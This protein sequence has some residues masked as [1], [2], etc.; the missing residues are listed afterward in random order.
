MERMGE[1]LWRKLMDNTTGRT[2]GDSDV[3]VSFVLIGVECL[4][5][6]ML[7]VRF[8]VSGPPCTAC[9]ALQSGA[10]LRRASDFCR[11]AGSH[12]HAPARSA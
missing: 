5:E 1:A 2:R 8:F 3:D 4:S 7:Y 11:G 6:E 9:R 10:S 12:R